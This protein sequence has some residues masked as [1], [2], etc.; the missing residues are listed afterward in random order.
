MLGL[1]LLLTLSRGLL[2]YV[3]LNLLVLGLWGA[4]NF[5]ALGAL[6]LFQG[7]LRRQLPSPTLTGEQGEAFLRF[8]NW[9]SALGCSQRRLVCSEKGAWFRGSMW[10]CMWIWR[11]SGDPQKTNL[12]RS[13]TQHMANAGKPIKK[14]L[15]LNQ[16]KLSS[17]IKKKL[18]SQSKKTFSQSKKTFSTSLQASLG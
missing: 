12:T 14:K 9:A 3:D 8:A 10:R 17:K 18:F 6:R 13:P 1:K 11:I 4:G 5:A 7:F 16:K 2:R 15:F